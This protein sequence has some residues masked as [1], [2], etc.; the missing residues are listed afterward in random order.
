MVLANA[1]YF[2]A[3]WRYPFDEDG[4][5]P[6]PVPPAGRLQQE[7]SHDEHVEEEL[8]YSNGDGF[9]A[10]SLPYNGGMSMIVIVPDAGKFKE[11]E[12]TLDAE[13]VDLLFEDFSTFDVTLKMPRFEFESEFKLSES[14]EAMGMS[15]AFD[16][17]LLSSKADFSGMDGRACVRGDRPCLYIDEVIHKSFVLV[18]EEGTEAAAATAVIMLGLQ[19]APVYPQVDLTID[20]P[21]IFLIHDWGT[22]TILFVGRV[23]RP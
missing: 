11:F 3:T 7:R 2:N 16:D 4:T 9:Q 13:L 6:C 18:D 23:E 19:S 12:R 8:W 5:E 10:V 14:L 22:D 1:I 21:F 17:D 20:R 15:H